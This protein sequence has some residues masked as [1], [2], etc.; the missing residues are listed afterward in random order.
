M[1]VNKNKKE[2][3]YVKVSTDF[4]STGYMQPRCNGVSYAKIN[5]TYTIGDAWVRL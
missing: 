1:A 4:D 2:K 3:V 5:G